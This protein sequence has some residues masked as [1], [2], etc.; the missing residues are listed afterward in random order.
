MF[1]NNINRIKSAEMLTVYPCK[2]HL[3]PDEYREAADMGA[4]DLRALLYVPPDPDDYEGIVR[5]KD[6][7]EESYVICFD[8]TI[9]YMLDPEYDRSNLNNK[10]P[11]AAG[12]GSW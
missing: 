5:F 8:D 4:F 12:W 7:D 9:F 3:T 1:V 6:A 11:K 10:H 2:Y